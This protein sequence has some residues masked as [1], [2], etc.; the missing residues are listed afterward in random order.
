M[1]E[2][3]FSSV[4]VDRGYRGHAQVGAN[5]VILP[6]G[7]RGKSAYARRQHK[8]RCRR[9]SGIEAVIGHL[10]ADHRLSRNYLKGIAGDSMNALLAG[11]G[12]NYRVLL[13]EIDFF[14][15][16]VCVPQ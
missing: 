1:F 10:K 6:R 5:E 2:K 15:L 9:R 16:I 11:I 7:C 4:I 13:R 14:A 12:S 3:A 8:L